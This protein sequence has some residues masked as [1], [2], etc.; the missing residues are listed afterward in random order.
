MNVLEPQ[1]T[2]EVEIRLHDAGR[3]MT[4]GE[5]RNQL[6]ENCNGE[7]FCFIDDD[8][9]VPTY[10]VSEL[11]KAIEQTPDV[12]TFI[13]HMTTNGINRREFTIKLHS[14]YEERNGHY[15]RFP[16]HLACFRRALVQ[17]IKFPHKHQR[18]D[19]EWASQINALGI[20]KTEVHIT[21]GMYHYDFVDPIKRRYD[22]VGIRR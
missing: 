2:D 9:L 1:K 5:K 18:E 15:Y 17:H 22:P 21:R 20:L 16:N 12:V 8:D 4:T 19:Y 13:G 3:S 11:L 7:Y 14:K 10:Y 6:I